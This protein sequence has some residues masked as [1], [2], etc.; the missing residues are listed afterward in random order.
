MATKNNSAGFD[1]PTVPYSMAEIV[2]GM[3][4]LGDFIADVAEI[5]LEGYDSVQ[6]ERKEVFRQA[7]D[8]LADA[9]DLLWA[10]YESASQG[11]QYPQ[12]V[13]LRNAYHILKE[14]LQRLIELTEHKPEDYITVLQPAIIAMQ[15]IPIAD[16][17]AVESTYTADLAIPEHVQTDS[18]SGEDQ[19]QNND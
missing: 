14:A 4:N 7:A 17:T 5:F 19:S 18:S 10:A 2:E 13:R 8:N 1:D 15:E 6:T 3:N 11:D 9:Y 12:H 16:D